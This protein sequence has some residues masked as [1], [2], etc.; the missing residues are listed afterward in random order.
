MTLAPAPNVS[1]ENSH[2]FSVIFPW[3]AVIEVLKFICYAGYYT[4]IQ[5]P[6][7]LAIVSG[8]VAKEVTARGGY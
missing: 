1:S 8:S 3:L 5:A 4:V 6:G 7:Y 2:L